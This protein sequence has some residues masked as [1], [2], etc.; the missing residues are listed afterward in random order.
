M[1]SGIQATEMRGQECLIQSN[2]Q[3]DRRRIW[4]QALVGDCGTGGGVCESSF[5]I[6]PIS[7]GDRKQG[8]TKKMGEEGLL[9]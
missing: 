7:Q 8:L 1:E 5:Q 9:A 6:T 3:E 2:E 4:T